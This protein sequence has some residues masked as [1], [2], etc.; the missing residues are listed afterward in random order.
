MIVPNSHQP[1]AGNAQVRL[2]ERKIVKTIS[3]K[4]VAAVAVASLG[5]GLLSV[6]PASANAVAR[7]ASAVTVNNQVV[8]AATS[9]Q[10]LGTITLSANLVSANSDTI[11]VSSLT[12]PT[13]ATITVATI[14]GSTIDATANANRVTVG[15]TGTFTATT[16]NSTSGAIVGT[17]SAPGTYVLTIGGQAVTIIATGQTAAI[18]PLIGDGLALNQEKTAT[19]GTTMN[20]VAGAFNTVT[21]GVLSGSGVN[22]TGAG[23]YGT[24]GRRTLLT[25]TGAGATFG[26]SGTVSSNGATYTEN[27]TAFSIPLAA[28]SA[29]SATANQ[30]FSG[31]GFVRVNTPNVGTV[32]VSSFIETANFG[33]FSQTAA[34]TITITVNAA[35]SNG[36]ISSANS[37]SVIK[38]TASNW[39]AAT[40]AAAATTDDTV[41]VVGTTASLSTPVAVV[42]V[43]LTDAVGT[44]GTA[45]V[46]ATVGATI[47]GPGTLKLDTSDNSNSTGERL[48]SLSNG[49]GH[50]YVRVFPDG[51]AGKSTI[52]ITVSGATGTFTSTETVTFLGAAKT[53]SVKAIEP[54]IGVGTV[55]DVVEILAK[56]S[57]DQVTTATFTALSSNTAVLSSTLTDCQL[58][59]D[60]QIAL[61]SAKGAY[62]CD[63]SGVAAGTATLTIN[64]AS[65][66]TNSPT[67]AIRVTKGVISKITMTTNKAT[68]APGEKITLRLTAEDADGQLLGKGAAV[69]NI[70]NG[71]STVTNASLTG[72]AFADAGMDFSAGVAETTYY[73]PYGVGPMTFSATLD[74][75]SAV[76]TALQATKVTVTATVVDANQATLLTQIDALNAKIVAL[77]ALIA[78]IM[79]KLGVR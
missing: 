19:N 57:L 68:Y 2:N 12:G 23:A 25:V 34:A 6:V 67:V 55:T 35:A 22:A 33:I 7:T 49:G 5:F 40:T 45:N 53:I 42:R 21:I 24:A 65:T 52:T 37:R 29:V 10:A 28:T 75:V 73:A 62:I 11:A 27:T 54:H 30:A 41:N 58:A 39:A 60:A 76:A 38:T 26:A 3:L 66:T 8:Q 18:A 1:H 64:P 78:K 4:K 36:I 56:D 77:N 20:A 50:L 72:T 14:G 43:T 13:G 31:G 70:L 16:A 74:S 17:V 48:A 9:A 46:T 47:A 44:S 69:Y 79:K 59:T 51:T 63:L 61:G 15:G 71:A 32:T